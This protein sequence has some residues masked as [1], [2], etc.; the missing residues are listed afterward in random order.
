MDVAW[1]M[2]YWSNFLFAIILKKFYQAYWMSGHFT[3]KL[4]VI[5][6]IKRLLIQLVIG[7]VV[8]VAVLAVGYYYL[9]DNLIK[10]AMIGII[11]LGNLYG[12]VLLV[13]LLAYGVA[14][15][16]LSI[17][18]KTNTELRLYNALLGTQESWQEFRDARLEY[19]K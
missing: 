18:K 19:L 4:K 7:M 10:I 13:L 8:G 6:A 17:W 3:T 15:V 9:G 2:V 16:P 5:D 1:Q 14:F 12:M 11:L